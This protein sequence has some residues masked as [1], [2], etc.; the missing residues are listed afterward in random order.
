MLDEGAPGSLLSALDKVGFR[1]WGSGKGPLMFPG[2]APPLSVPPTQELSL[3]FTTYSPY[4]RVGEQQWA[5]VDLVF[6]ER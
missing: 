4:S 3:L 2:M 5:T 1:P 6:P